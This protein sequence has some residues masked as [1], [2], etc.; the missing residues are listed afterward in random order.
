MT[1]DYTWEQVADAANRIFA[2]HV[3]SYKDRNVV[4][5]VY[6]NNLPRAI[7]DIGAMLWQRQIK[8]TKDSQLLRTALNQLD[9]EGKIGNGQ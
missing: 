4:K 7:C 5:E 8:E 6:K 9:K 1:V 2:K 3:E